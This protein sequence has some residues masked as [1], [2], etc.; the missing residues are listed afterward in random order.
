MVIRTP[1]YNNNNHK[2]NNDKD[3]IQRGCLLD[4]KQIQEEQ[5]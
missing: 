3:F 5:L 2:N 1:V 4:T